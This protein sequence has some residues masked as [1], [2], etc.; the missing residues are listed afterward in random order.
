MPLE[1]ENGV[2]GVH[3]SVTTER[4]SEGFSIRIEWIDPESGFEMHHD[5]HFGP[6]DDADEA[7][8]RIGREI[9]KI[10]NVLFEQWDAKRRRQGLQ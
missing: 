10:G 3:F 6:T 8:K 7:E 2:V 1:N 4:D 9:L 5:L